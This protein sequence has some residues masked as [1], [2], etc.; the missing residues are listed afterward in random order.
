MRTLRGAVTRCG[1]CVT[2][3]V[4]SLAPQV[5]AQPVKPNQCATCHAS[6]SEPTLAAPV[7]ATIG[8]VHDKTGVRCADCHGGDPGAID[9]AAAHAAAHGY[10]G[11]PSG[12]T[13]CATCHVLL[14]EKFKTSAHAQIFETACV[15]CHSN[16]GVKKPSD[17]MLGTAS[18][19]VCASCHSEKDDP[20][21]VAANRMRAGMD[22]LRGGI[23]A[24]GDL[25]S[26]A[27]NAGMEVGDQELAL[28]EAGTTLVLARTEMHSFNPD[29][30][31]AVIGDGIKIVTAVNEG[32][33]RALAELRYRRRGLFLSLGA[34]LIFVAALGLKIRSLN[35]RH[36]H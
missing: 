16:H 8:D 23:A 21:F 31:D 34:I 25:V 19:A 20:G 12:A 29:A 18:D 14:N 35:Q 30:L 5:R 22:K 15:E 17:A 1:L 11:K 6:L 7:K 2:A 33:N 36:P 9:K 28:H 32:G 24:A 10:R 13:I 26:R 4:L 27:R 3:I